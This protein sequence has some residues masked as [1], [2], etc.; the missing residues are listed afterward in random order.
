MTISWRVV[1]ILIVIGMIVTVAV[2]AGIALNSRQNL[3]LHTQ[4]RERIAEFYKALDT[5][6]IGDGLPEAL[7]KMEKFATFYKL[8][9]PIFHCDAAD[10]SFYLFVF[11]RTSKL[12]YV[13]RH[14]SLA[15]MPLN[16]TYVLPRDKSG[17]PLISDEVK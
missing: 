7:D 8:G 4:N 9:L 13:S 2:F 10:G 17:R 16:G 15:D 14:L 11:D 1:R 3:L 5:I 6:E 12:A